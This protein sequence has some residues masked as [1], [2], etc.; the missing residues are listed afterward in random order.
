MDINNFGIFHSEVWGTVSDWVMV[1]VTTLTAIFLYFSLKSQRQVQKMQQSLT[2]IEQNNYLHKI[3]PDFKCKIIWK[4]K[5]EDYFQAWLEVEILDNIP[6]N[7]S[8][9][10]VQTSNDF[11]DISGHKGQIDAQ[12][13]QVGSNLHFAFKFKNLAHERGLIGSLDIL[14]ED[15]IGTIYKI[16][17]LLISTEENCKKAGPMVESFPTFLQSNELKNLFRTN[18]RS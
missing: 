6:F 4:E 10:F 7:L 18:T 11:K 13:N 8:Y 17:F 2:I 3:R 9:A 12:S 15:S 14:F 16:K 1:V 5:L